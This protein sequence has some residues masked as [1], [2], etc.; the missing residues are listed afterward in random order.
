MAIRLLA[1]DLDGTLLTPRGELTERNRAAVR[2]ACEAGVYVTVVTGRRFRDARPLVWQLGLDDVPLISHNGALTKHVNTLETVSATLLPREAAREVLRVG[3]GAGADA[4]VSTDPHGAGV[5]LYERISAGNRALEAYL[6]WSAHIH[7]PEA[8]ESVR[9]VP[10]L[11]DYFQ[12]EP[13]H[14]S[15]SGGCA[16]MAALQKLLE[17]ELGDAVKIYATIYPPRDFTLLDILNPSVSKATGLAA[18]AAEINAA[19]AEIMAVGDNFNDLSMLRYAGT[20]VIMANA[21]AELRAI[22]GFHRTAANTED[23]V[24][25]AIEKFILTA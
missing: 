3:R 7:G 4:L 13:I 11:D 19:P 16:P 9:R 22:P 23:G 6:K 21:D 14:M 15:F 2:A 25:Q 12:E 17:Q 20:A 1:L 10:S 8:G 18:A 5:M 24:A